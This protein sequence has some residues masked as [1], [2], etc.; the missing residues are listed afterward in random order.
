[1]AEG[2]RQFVLRMSA[3]GVDTFVS[4]LRDAAKE[5][6]QARSALDQLTLLIVG[7]N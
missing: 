3:D 1:M 2:A 5:S 6:T 7:E 4:K